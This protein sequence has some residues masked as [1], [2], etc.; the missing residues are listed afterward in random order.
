[1]FSVPTGDRFDPVTNTTE[2][3]SFGRPGYTRAFFSTG[4]N[5]TGNSLNPLTMAKSLIEQYGVKSITSL[6]ALLAQNDEASQS[7]LPPQKK[8]QT[9][10][11]FPSQ[12]RFLCCRTAPRRE[13]RFIFLRSGYFAV[14]CPVVT[15]DIVFP[16][17]IH[18]CSPVAIAISPA[19]EPP[20]LVRYQPSHAVCSFRQCLT[21]PLTFRAS[22]SK[23]KVRP[24][25]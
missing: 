7:V 23:C 3:D 18:R 11:V 20:A 1:M 12:F 2:T 5:I 24:L 4:A 10:L 14:R 6:G 16:P 13:S 25:D 22:A 15:P 19:P 9:A 21:P 8:L 17:E